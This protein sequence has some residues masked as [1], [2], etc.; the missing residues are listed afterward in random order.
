[1]EVVRMYKTTY[2]LSIEEMEELQETLYQQL[3]DDGTIDIGEFDG[4]TEEMVHEHYSGI[5]F[6][7]DDFFC[8]IK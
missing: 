1:M 3:L 6:V 5:S 4:V 2:D 7:D 8:N